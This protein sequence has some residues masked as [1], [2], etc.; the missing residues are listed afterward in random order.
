MKRNS[1]TRA[2]ALS[3]TLALAACGA[4]EDAARKAEAKAAAGAGGGSSQTVT[5]AAAALQNL[6][7]IV[8]ASGTISAW[9]EV[10][11]GAEAGGLTATGVY[12]DE[13]R[14]V[15]QGQPLVQL[16]DA[17]L[18]AQ[19]RQQQAGV[20][21]AQA[22]AAR[23]Q[24]AL[25]RA[26]ELK[27]RGFLSQASL[28]TA[29]ANQRASAA[30]L[31]AAQASLSETRTRLAQAT[32]RAPVSGLVISRSVTRGQIVAPGT[33]LFRIVRDGRLELDAQVPETE[34]A[35]V[36]AG[37]SAVISSDQV[38]ETTGT[39]RIVTPEVNTETRLGIARI[40]VSGGGFRPGMFARARIQ[41]GDQAAVTVPTPAV[42]YREN[43]AG[44][45][46]LG[47]D[48]RARFRP[49]VVL[50]R[51]T[52]RTAVTG[53]EAGVRVVVEGAGF[54]GEGDRVTVAGARP[55]AA[56]PVARGSVAAA[57]K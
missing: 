48:G 36:R 39:V 9:E 20:Q 25:A 56:T 55:P 17:L 40:A 23:D 57:K 4:G 33:E 49:V 24:S 18:R 38:G 34:L 12:V 13:G 26:Q 19:L 5:V 44:V 8:T 3:L 29:L 52:D 46:V 6:P 53:I 30:N 7:R 11:V 28:D 45:F 37:Q 42:L 16:N 41:V 47:A 31:L 10:P 35:L 14:Y 50:S 1:W 51:T 43:R 15:R 2:I 22:N 27:E 21:T 32:I 54:L